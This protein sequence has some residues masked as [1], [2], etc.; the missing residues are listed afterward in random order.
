MRT[1]S[2]NR[3]HSERVKANRSN[4]WGHD[5]RGDKRKL[6]IVSKTPHPCS[7]WQC[8]NKRKIEGGTLKEKVTTCEIME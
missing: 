6:G 5:L 7:C 2:E 4:Y 3:H 1:R 8:G